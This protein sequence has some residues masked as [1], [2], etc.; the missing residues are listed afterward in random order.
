MA[1]KVMVFH[2][3]FITH[4]MLQLASIF[5]LFFSLVCYE[6]QSQLNAEHRQYMER[7]EKIRVFC[8]RVDMNDFTFVSA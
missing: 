4:S 3:K 5:L 1:H 2:E 6:K 7:V 8:E